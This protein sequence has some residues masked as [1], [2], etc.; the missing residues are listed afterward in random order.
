MGGISLESYLFNV[1]FSY[2]IMSWT[3]SIA[4]INIGVGNYIPYT[5]SILLGTL[6]GLIIN[7]FVK[8]IL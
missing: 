6:F 3:W 8:R 2:Y 5:I 1:T 7:K 4:G